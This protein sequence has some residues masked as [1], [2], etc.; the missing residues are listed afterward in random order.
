MITDGLPVVN[1]ET[2]KEKGLS[3][4]RKAISRVFI[5]SPSAN[6]LIYFSFNERESTSLSLALD[7]N[8]KNSKVIPTSKSGWRI[9]G[10]TTSPS[11]R[12]LV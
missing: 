10:K 6:P 8:C 9:R 7:Q 12:R 2:D 3:D 4:T 5:A 11:K 1:K